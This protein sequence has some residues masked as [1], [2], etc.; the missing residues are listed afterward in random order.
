MHEAVIRH[1]LYAAPYFTTKTASAGT[2]LGLSTVQE[3]VEEGGGTVRLRSAVGC[4]STFMIV[5]PLRDR[6][7]A[8]VRRLIQVAV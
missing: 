2:G 8:P 3:I 6:Y 5:W 7:P 4:G 1:P